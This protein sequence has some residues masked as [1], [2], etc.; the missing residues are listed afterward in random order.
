MTAPGRLRLP[1]AAD[2]AELEAIDDRRFQN[3]LHAPEFSQPTDAKSTGAFA[4]A[5]KPDEVVSVAVIPKE[6]II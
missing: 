3:R 4:V 5:T 2:D 6:A 1:D